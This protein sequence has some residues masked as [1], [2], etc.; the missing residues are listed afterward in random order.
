MENWKTIQNELVMQIEK[1]VGIYRIH[2]FDLFVYGECTIRVYENQ[3]GKFRARCGVC[4]RHKVNHSE[5]IMEEKGE[6]ELEAL[7]NVIKVLYQFLESYKS[8]RYVERFLEYY[9]V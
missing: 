6:S 8:E 1:C 2:N 7:Q 4:Y 3:Q 5:L 9:R